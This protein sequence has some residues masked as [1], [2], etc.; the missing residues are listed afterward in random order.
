MVDLHYIRTTME[1]AHGWV[2]FAAG[3]LDSLAVITMMAFIVVAT[4]LGLTRYLRNV[5]H[6]YTRYRI[7]LARALQVG[8]ELLVAA[9]IIRT[10]STPLTALN[11]L[12]LG[13]VVLVRTFLGW[14]LTIEIEGRW[15]WQ[16][17][18]EIALPTSAEN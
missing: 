3:G 17:E 10:V 4:A 8:L 16:Q 5:E 11:L 7:A 9:D 12:L 6:A 15:P 18:K 13:G 1:Q 14:T 2:E